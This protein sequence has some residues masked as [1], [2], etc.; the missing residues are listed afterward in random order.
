MKEHLLRNIRRI[1]EKNNIEEE[2][3][4]LFIDFYDDMI[5]KGWIRGGCHTLSSLLHIILNEFG[6]CNTLK[7]GI[8]Q[9][10]DIR[11]SHSWIELNS[12]IF[13]ISI[14]VTNYETL[15]ISNVIFWSYDIETFDRV[16]NAIYRKMIDKSP[17]KTG[18]LIKNCTVRSYLDACPEGGYAFWNY[19][20]EFS[21]RHNKYLNMS[22]LKD[23]YI[24]TKWVIS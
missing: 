20:L 17:D 11:F 24:D 8:V 13:D 15:H 22:R 3:T 16:N 4:T 5:R 14:H 23:K 2:L 6:Y 19:I 9:I 21:K 10:E 18:E 1:A 7:L 12:N